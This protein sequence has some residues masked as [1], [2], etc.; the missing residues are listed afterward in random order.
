VFGLSGRGI[1]LALL[2]GRLR[3]T[4]GLFGDRRPPAPAD[5]LEFVL[6]PEPPVFRPPVAPTVTN[7]FGIPG[8]GTA[9]SRLPQTSDAV[10]RKSI[11]SRAF[12][13]GGLL[14]FGLEIFIEAANRKQKKKIDDITQRDE[15]E[16]LRRDR[17]RA[18]DLEIF[19]IESRADLPTINPDAPEISPDLDPVRPIFLPEPA[20]PRPDVLFPLEFPIEIEFPPPS[21]ETAPAPSAP[22]VSPA[23][24][25]PD[26]EP[27]VQ[28]VRFPDPGQFESPNPFGAV[29]QQPFEFPLEVPLIIGDLLERADPFAQPDLTP[30]ESPSVPSPLQVPTP[31]L[32]ARVDPFAFDQPLSQP[33]TTPTTSASVDRCKP[34]K[35]EED[36]EEPRTECFK[37]LYR[38]SILSTDFTAWTEIDCLTGREL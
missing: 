7:P 34:R 20:S 19:T 31:G 30:L 23:I 37:G 2:E 6:N 5:P 13:L 9:T 17:A 29:G 24:P 15:E 3:F 28:P 21:F 16:Q 12:N 27:V 10:F 22:D 26:L 32:D 4:F 25:N 35:C 14:I 1:F 38:E 11:A 33:F 36:L 18:R 8:F